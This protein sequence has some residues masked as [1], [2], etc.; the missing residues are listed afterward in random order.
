M[1]Y[2]YK[3]PVPVALVVTPNEPFGAVP[4]G[5]LENGKTLKAWVALKPLFS[6]SCKLFG[7][8]DWQGGSTYYSAGI[9][10][11]RAI[12]DPAVPA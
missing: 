2:W 3:E 11:L 7:L 9:T 1:R 5:I 8:F 6:D 10:A 12:M 4:E